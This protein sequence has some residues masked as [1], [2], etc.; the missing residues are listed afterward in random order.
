MVA[1]RLKGSLVIKL[2]KQVLSEVERK[3]SSIKSQLWSKCCISYFRQR[4][5]CRVPSSTQVNWELDIKDE[6]QRDIC[7]VAWGTDQN[8]AWEGI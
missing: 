8:T 5:F 3:K 6:K 1:G 2:L 7:P 4:E